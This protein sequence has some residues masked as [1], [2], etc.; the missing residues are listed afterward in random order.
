[1][2]ITSFDFLIFIAITVA[3]YYLVVGKFRWIVLLIASG[4]FY[5][6]FTIPGLLILIATGIL[7]WY[8]ADRIQKSKDEQNIW[9]AEN[10]KFV[11]KETRKAKK[12]KFQK[13]Q[14]NWVKAAVI[15]NVGSLFLFKYYGVLAGSVNNLLNTRFWTAE[16]LLLPL[17]IS[18]YT[19]MLI[20]YVLDVSR[21]LVRAEKNPAKV[22]LF[23]G[24]FLSIMQGP[25]NRYN[26]LIPQIEQAEKQKFTLLRFKKSV[27]RIFWGYVKKMCIADQAAVIAGEIFGNYTEYAGLGIIFGMVCFAVQ[28]YADFSGYMDI[29]LGIGE[30]L[31]IQLPENFWQP[32]FSRNMS[33]FWKRWHITLGLWLQDYV[34]YP[35]LKSKW[36]KEVGSWITKSWG[37]EIGRT[38]PTY[39]GMFMLWTLIGA[40]HGV[41]MNYVFGVGILQFLYIFTGEICQP[42]TYKC[43]R[44]LRINESS[45][46]WHVFQSVRCTCLMMFAWVFF[47]SSTFGDAIGFLKRIFAEGI[48][49]HQ[50]TKMFVLETS[51]L[52]WNK[53]MIWMLYILIS[54]FVLLFVDFMREHQIGIREKIAVKSL[55]VYLATILSMVAILIVFGAY[56]VQ[57]SASNFIYFEF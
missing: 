39:I 35:I 16:N 21:D 47:N 53:P 23:A 57:Y 1:M 4:Y 28:L 22:I 46:W 12:E 27:L 13:Y 43:K 5:C 37:K 56:G 11:D 9:M 33:E 14:S 2:S 26:K 7:T 17:G 44:K 45:N 49:Y 8:I 55:P 20:G 34:F 36:L 52:V 30:L 51:A 25:F 6:N 24:F 54:I 10:K 18:Y 29:I 38:I 41:G 31:G 3:I 15:L 40:W 32:F 48:S 50:I 19:L 42:L